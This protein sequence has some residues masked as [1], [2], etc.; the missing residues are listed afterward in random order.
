MP[1]CLFDFVIFSVKNSEV[2]RIEEKTVYMG[3]WE[4]R[5]KQDYTLQCSAQY[6]TE[7]AV[8]TGGQ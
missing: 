7:G 6:N 8:K 4:F 3:P 1:F 5:S 2:Q